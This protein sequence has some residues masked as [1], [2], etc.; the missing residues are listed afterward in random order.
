[1]F[2]GP[3]QKLGANK[4]PKKGG[5]Q[6]KTKRSFIQMIVGYMLLSVTIML[7]GGWTESWAQKPVVLR[8]ALIESTDSLE[9]VFFRN[10]LNEVAKKAGGKIQIQAY[11]NQSLVKAGRMLESLVQGV[12]DIAADWSCYTPGA[13]PLSQVMDLPLTFPSTE[14]ATRLAEY[15][16]GK[17]FANAKEYQNIHLLMFD[18][19]DPTIIMSTNKPIRT[20]QDLKGMELRA[21]A[22]QVAFVKALG[23]VPAAMPITEAYLALNKG[24]CKGIIIPP[25]DFEAYRLADVINYATMVQL[26]TA[27]RWFGINK[28]VWKSLPEDVQKAFE[29]GIPATRSASIKSWD[30]CAERGWKLFNKKGGEIITPSLAESDKFEKVCSPVIE[31]WITEKEA[32]GLPARAIV[33]DAVDFLKKYKK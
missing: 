25:S 12:C 7:L 8:W 21:H 18:A 30:L 11:P 14:A 32:M 3:T 2:V 20:L 17:Y 22:G 13:L 31:N 15:L 28:D 9:M 26:T 16:H 4:D 27:M 19:L 1:M 24:I 6:M 29:E 33:K 10:Y 5:N 23:A